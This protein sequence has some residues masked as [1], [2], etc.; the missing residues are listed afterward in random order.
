[1]FTR[2]R[3]STACKSKVDQLRQ[4]LALTW[5][6]VR[7]AVAQILLCVLA[8]LMMVGTLALLARAFHAASS[9]NAAAI[10]ATDIGLGPMY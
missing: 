3:N 6:A 2:G 4:L 10:V 1:M 9:D 8:L 5:R 7:A